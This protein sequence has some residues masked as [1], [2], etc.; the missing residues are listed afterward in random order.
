MQLN[1]K[2]IAYIIKG[3]R[4]IEEKLMSDL[5]L[6]EDEAVF[7]TIFYVN[8]SLSD[9]ENGQL[10]RKKIL[11]QELF[12]FVKEKRERF[13][14]WFSLCAIK[15]ESYGEIPSVAYITTNCVGPRGKGGT[16]TTS[17]HVV[18][19][20]HPPN[21][22]GCWKI[23]EGY[24]DFSGKLCTQICESGYNSEPY[25]RYYPVQWAHN[26]PQE[27]VDTIYPIIKNWG[28]RFKLE[29]DTNELLKH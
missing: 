28:Y 11:L 6:L 19:A 4:A 9:K 15:E 26:A 12:S 7:V 16:H 21:L 27:I 10:K 8:D 5:L 23:W 29:L 25:F 20:L 24:T 13:G 17:V 1:E 14:R 22:G 2:Q 3:S 18:R